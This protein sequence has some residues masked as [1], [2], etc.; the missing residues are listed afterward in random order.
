MRICLIGDFSS[1]FDE[2]YK[3]AAKYLR[4]QLMVN[5]HAMTSL[6]VKVGWLQLLRSSLRLTRPDVVHSISAPTLMSFILLRLLQI[7]W[8]GVRTVLSGLNPSSLKL[9]RQ[10]WVRPLLAVLAPSAVVTQSEMLATFFTDLGMD[11]TAIPNG[12]DLAR[13]APVTP[14]ERRALRAARGIATDAFVV[15]HV[16]H[17]SHRRNLRALLPLQRPGCQVII[18]GSTYIED[19]VRLGDEL[20]QAGCLVFRGYV[21][22]IEELY[23]LADCYVFPLQPGKSLFMPLSVLEAMGTNAVVVTTPYEGLRSF[24]P[25]SPGVRYLQPDAADLV[26]VMTRLRSECP[27]DPGT[28]ALVEPCDWPVVLAKLEA[29]YGRAASRAGQEQRVWLVD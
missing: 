6:D 21:E 18:A 19:D 3:N 13:F 20:E 27:T 29:V 12:V 14:D 26:E 4:Q 8:F 15:L 9:T 23:Q 10:R 17:L 24:F 28:R 11:V 7:R 16:G 1:G 22:R 25:A 5:G 2:G